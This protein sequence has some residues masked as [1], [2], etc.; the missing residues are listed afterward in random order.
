MKI[1]KTNSISK[2]S[3]E[4]GA[5]SAAKVILD[6]R[7]TLIGLMGLTRGITLRKMMV[8]SKRKRPSSHVSRPEK[9]QCNSASTNVAASS[10]LM[11]S[12]AQFMHHSKPRQHT[13]SG[14]SFAR[15]NS[16]PLEDAPGR[17]PTES[18]NNGGGGEILDTYIY[19]ADVDKL[20]TKAQSGS[21]G[22]DIHAQAYSYQWL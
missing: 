13:E 2:W 17:Q 14:P 10:S 9:R 4:V 15:K 5:Q 11:D 22:G 20:Q 3:E 8:L 18:C 19:R 7:Y 21:L 1:L 6:F 16:P 12:E